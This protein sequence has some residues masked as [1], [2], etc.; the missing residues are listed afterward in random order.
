MDKLTDHPDLQDKTLDELAEINRENFDLIMK[1]CRMYKFPTAKHAMFLMGQATNKALLKLGVKGLNMMATARNPRAV[2]THLM[3]EIVERQMREKNVFV[4]HQKYDIE[5]QMRRSMQGMEAAG[6]ED[7]A[8]HVESS[9]KLLHNKEHDFRRTGMYFYHGNEIAYFISDPIKRD[10][11]TEGGITIVGQ[12][13]FEVYTNVP[14][15]LG[16]T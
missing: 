10:A 9:I 5:E 11:M 7:G 8:E 12:Y 16:S 6:D 3:G 13:S 14:D 4:Q 1:Q 2:N 15:P